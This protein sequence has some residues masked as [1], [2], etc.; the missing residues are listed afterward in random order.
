MSLEIKVSEMSIDVRVL[1][2]RRQLASAKYLMAEYMQ[3]IHLWDLTNKEILHCTPYYDILTD[4]EIHLGK[5]G[6]ILS[7][8]LQQKIFSAVPVS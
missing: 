3:K 2:D 5:L 1:L 4:T 6:T 8:D 7:I